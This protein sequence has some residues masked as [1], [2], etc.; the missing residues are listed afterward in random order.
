[1]KF[2]DIVVPL[3]FALLIT[4][5]FNYFFVARRATETQDALR[6][7]QSFKAPLSEELVKPLNTEVSFIG[8]KAPEAISLVTVTTPH[9]EAVFSQQAAAL[10]RLSFK[11]A[12]NTE[13][14]LLSTITPPMST[15]REE[16]PFLVALNKQTPY[17]YTLLSK[18][19]EGGIHTVIYQA[20]TQDVRITKKYLVYD[21]VY[22]LDLEITLEPK[23]VNSQEGI[24]ARIFFPA[25]LLL[26]LN[27][28]D[29]VTGIVYNERNRVQKIQPADLKQ[30]VW[31]APTLFGAQ[32]RYFIHALVADQQHFTQRA[33][34]TFTSTDALEAILEGPV[35]H[36]KTTWTLSFYCG[37]KEAEHLTVVDPRLEETLDYGWFAV[38]SKFLLVMLKFLYGYVKNYGWAILILTLI[39]KIVLLPITLKGEKSAQKQMEFQKKLH[40]IEQKYKHDR[41]ALA[42][43]KLELSR[44]YGVSTLGGLLSPLLQLPIFIGL[45]RV[46]TNSY[47]LY[48]APFIGWITDLSA[49]DK[50]YILPVIA[51][52]GMALQTA[53]AGDIR[54][55]VTSLII[56]A[57]V[58]G[59]FINF[60]AGLIL[61]IGANTLLGVAQT[62]IQKMLKLV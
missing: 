51:G 47:E 61:Y 56:A 21:D 49:P 57:I 59:I 24:Q 5:G 37:P 50:Y 9:A 52:I 4:L 20:E 6:S 25:P 17:Y 58:T 26:Q 23:K 36:E 29:A 40:Y 44:K 13:Q 18:T 34:Y 35:I 53:A 11:H 39:I 27:P 7:G 19:S 32:N 48:Q 8:E 43:E 1:M 15:A 60:P 45:N 3:S 41:E 30:Q 2:Q 16:Q 62:K 42:R 55:R 54:K 10:E 12:H 46:L 38:I 22:K 31:I 33:Y 14:K 28:K